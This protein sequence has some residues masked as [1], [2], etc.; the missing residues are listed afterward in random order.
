MCGREGSLRLAEIEGGELNVCSNCS[1]YG[2]VKSKGFRVKNFSPNKKSFR[3]KVV[4]E[5]R[6][7]RNY[8]QLIRN[9]RE[10]KGMTQEDFAKSLNEKESILAKWESG[11]LKPRIGI[12]RRLERILEIKLVEKD[13]VVPLNKDD[14]KKKVVD[15]EFTLGHF[16]KKPR[17]RK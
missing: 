12:A 11:T 15:D 3:N 17:I 16:I 6:V 14:K 4:P 8:S 2:T 10:L 7:V 9:A 5:F 13:E 1:K